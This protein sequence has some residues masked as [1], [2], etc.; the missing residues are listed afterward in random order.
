MKEIS[1]SNEEKARIEKS[2]V[3]AHY[4][5]GYMGYATQYSCEIMKRYMIPGSVLEMGPAEGVMTD[6]LCDDFEDYTIVEGAQKFVDFIKSRH[7]K[8]KCYCSLFESFLPER[9]YDNIL[10]GHVLEHVENPVNILK[11][12]KKWLSNGGIILAAVPNSESIHRLAA[13]EMGL[14]SRTDELNERDIRHGHRRVYNWNSFMKDFT[15][16]GLKIEHGGG[17]WLKPISIP[18]ME[19]DWSVDML[20]AFLKLGERFP[21]NAAEMYVVASNNK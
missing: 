3:E 4:N 8:V 9:T 12:C 5:D 10:L 7:P 19:K 20:K 17:Y 11:I 13:V 2:A 14:L 15:S 18:Q 6:L 21:E 1:F 16:A